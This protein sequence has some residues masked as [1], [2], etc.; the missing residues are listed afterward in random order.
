M[1]KRNFISKMK[2][3]GGEIKMKKI[4]LTLVTVATVVSVGLSIALAAPSDS[5]SLGVTASV[6]APGPEVDVTILKFTDGN[7]D[8]DPWTNS[9]DVTSSMS[10]DF[11][12][13]THFYVDSQDG[14]TKD[15]G[16]WYSKAGYCV[17]VFAQ[18]YG[19]R[20]EIRSTCQGI[21]G[22]EDNGAYVFGITPVYSPDD[23]FVW[24]DGTKHKQLDRPIGSIMGTAGTA[25]AVNKRIYLSEPAPSTPRI[26]QVYYGIPPKNSDG[27]V[28]FSGWKGIPLTQTTGD[29]STTVTITIVEST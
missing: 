29:Y 9:T 11:G 2:R 28:P 13:L 19:K 14:K 27:T 21:A 15:A 12:E 25:V 26:L 1:F 5:K 10:P 18:G 8:Q 16:V 3:K 20:Y 7:P 17:V 4:L 23:A 22:L 6:T 24:A